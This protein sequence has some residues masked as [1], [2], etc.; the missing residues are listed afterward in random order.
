M[1]FT[2]V[3][4]QTSWDMR[5][6]ANIGASDRQ[7]LQLPLIQ[8]SGAG[9]QRRISSHEWMRIREQVIIV[10]GTF[11]PLWQSLVMRSETTSE[12][13]AI[14]FR[15]FGQYR[16]CDLPVKGAHSCV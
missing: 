10:F 6:R 12:C 16:L 15:S 8:K 13:S 14:R 5:V 11:M 1:P 2:G 3:R 7:N 4:L 9:H